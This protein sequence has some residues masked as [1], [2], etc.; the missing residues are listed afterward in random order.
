MRLATII[1]ALMPTILSAQFI[2]RDPGSAVGFGTQ[3][4][5]A[6]GVTFTSHSVGTGSNRVAYAVL[7]GW[8]AGG[9][10]TVTWGGTSMTQIADCGG[11]MCRIYRLLNP[12]SGTATV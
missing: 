5:N 3:S 8:Y 1:L 7:V 2:A 11:Q 9:N 4:S 12:P 6:S 10:P